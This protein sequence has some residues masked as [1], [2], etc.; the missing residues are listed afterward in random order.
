MLLTPILHF[1]VPLSK[2]TIRQLVHEVVQVI[3]FALNFILSNGRYTFLL[4]FAC[5]LLEFRFIFPDDFPTLHNLNFF[6]TSFDFLGFWLMT[7][8]NLAV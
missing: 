3:I 5:N 4:V 1:V 7:N 6:P 2:R 8:I